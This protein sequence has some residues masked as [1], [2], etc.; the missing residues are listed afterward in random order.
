MGFDGGGWSVDAKVSVVRR[1]KKGVT[2]FSGDFVLL[3]RGKAVE[4]VGWRVMTSRRIEVNYRVS[5]IME[6]RPLGG[7]RTGGP[8]A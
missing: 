4:L 7:V 3:S 6:Q 2:W 8:P 1:I 5:T